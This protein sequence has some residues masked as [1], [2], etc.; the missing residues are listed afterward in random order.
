VTTT[1]I[2]NA[3]FAG[4]AA[5]LI[6]AF[7]GTASAQ[8]FMPWEDVVKMAAKHNGMVSMED[9]TAFSER[10][11]QFAGFAPWVAENMK[12]LD[13]NH[14]GMVSMDE[15]KAWMIE[16]HMSNGDMI[17]IWYREVQK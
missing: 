14:D 10:E 4:L 16:H 11:K 5:A 8:G 1:Q 17:K 13:I 6:A 15:V 12:I 7:A 2:R 9:A 3:F